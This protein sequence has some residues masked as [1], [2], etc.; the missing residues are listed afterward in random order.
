MSDNSENSGREWEFWKAQ[1]QRILKLWEAQFLSAI[2][3][4]HNTSM[5]GQA[6]LKAA[7]L[8]NGVASVAL[9]AFVGTTMGKDIPYYLFLSLCSSMRCFVWGVLSAAIASGVTY[10]GGL[11]NSLAEPVDADNVNEKKVSK[12]NFWFWP[13]NLVA[14]ALVVLS[15]FLFYFGFS[16]AYSAFIN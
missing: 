14:I 8:I 4:Y 3:S 7:L 13:F 1:D 2:A 9:L 16:T 11:V 10:A 15:Y 5:Q 12:S 6:A